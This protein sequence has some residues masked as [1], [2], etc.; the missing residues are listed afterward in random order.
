MHNNE[1]QLKTFLINAGLVS[2]SAVE[3][4]LKEA[5]KND[6]SL[7]DELLT[8]EYLSEESVRRAQAHV[9]G[10]SYV[11]LDEESIDDDALLIVPESV[12]R[13]YQIAA[14]KKT[15]KTL[16]IALLNLDTLPK[17]QF[18]EEKTGLSLVPCLTDSDSLKRA[19]R[20]HQKRLK[21]SFGE[22]IKECVD[23]L[24][25]IDRGPEYYKGGEEEEKAI[26]EYLKKLAEDDQT[27]LL[28]SRVI[29]HA[30]REHASDIH[31]EPS[32]EILTIRYRID[33]VLHNAM[34]LPT[35]IHTA[36]TARAKYL[37]GL[38]LA[39]KRVPQ[40]G[41]CSVKIQEGETV[42]L[43][44]GTMPTQRGERIA[45]RILSHKAKGFTLEGLGFTGGNLDNLHWAL[46][47]KGGMVLVAGGAK[48]GKTTTLYTI[49]DILNTEKNA[50]STIEDPIEYQIP[51]VSQTQ[52]DPEQGLTFLRG[53]RGILRQDPDV[54]MISELRETELFSLC[55]NAALSGKRI[56]SALH[57]E[58]R[59]SEIPAL[60]KTAS[61]S[62][63]VSASLHAIVVQRL[64]RRL[65]P[66]AKKAKLSKKEQERLKEIVDTR[67]IIKLLREE[68]LAGERETLRDISFFKSDEK[69]KNKG[70][71]GMV[72]IY[73]VL[74]VTETI[75]ELIKD[76][77]SSE[78]IEEQAR[79]E[80]MV[81]LL[82]D[83]IIK[84][85][86]G[87]TTLDEVLQLAAG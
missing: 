34:E 75:K 77:V 38:I 66:N 12:A 30:R 11:H 4:A 52:V 49:L 72:G 81:N 41:V 6:T 16:S 21:S 17:I 46:Q 62:F 79:K 5:K 36:L 40:N 87:E 10:I 18:L 25:K 82:E 48:S 71:S 86:K 26:R 24:K 1:E 3:E 64:V 37:C 2:I 43:R 7:S 45:I 69:T 19:L 27:A 68:K 9:H 20:L 51:H 57:T 22:K 63:S 35:Y 78:V 23:N 29:L 47:K 70:F 13:T 42:S 80:G 83:G 50:I 61:A 54:V 65:T 74:P 56:F 58:K 84:A 31:I 33:G 32:G 60:L 53:L 8:K 55:Q 39:H 59:A 73:E 76:D 67:H 44:I 28:F 15:E 14:I 85:A